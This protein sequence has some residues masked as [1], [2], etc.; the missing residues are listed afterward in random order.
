MLLG[1]VEAARDAGVDVIGDTSD[2]ELRRRLEAA[3]RATLSGRVSHAEAMRRMSEADVVA[4]LYDPSIQANRYAAPNKFY[5][6]M[7]LGR[8][9][10]VSEGTPM[11]EWVAA[12]DCGWVVPYGNVDAL[13]RVLD[14]IL[15]D[16][17]AWRR[18]CE[19]ARRLFER[20]LRWPQEAERLEVAYRRLGLASH[21]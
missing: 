6:A 10:V 3:G 16:R 2:P 8:P 14:G 19:N 18:K 9:V 5:E 20:D 17:D 1:A 7:M 15:D 11:A 21:S 13:A 4:L 12:D